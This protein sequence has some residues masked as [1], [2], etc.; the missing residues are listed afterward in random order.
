MTDQP[1]VSI[2]MPVFNSAR[3]LAEAVESV[4]AQTYTNWEL[5]ICDDGSV[6]GSREIAFRYSERDPRRIRALAHP[7]GGN[8]GVSATRNLGLRHASGDLIAML[9]ADDVWL[10]RKLEEQV[11]LIERWS[12][13]VLVGTSRYWHGWTGSEVDKKRDWT[14]ATGFSSPSLLGPPDFL[15]AM[16]MREAAV[17]CP[18]SVIVTHE[19]MRDVGGYEDEF[20]RLYEDQ[21]LYV[22]LC[23]NAKVLVVNTVWDLY[24]QHSASICSTD[25]HLE[26]KARLRYLLWTQNY[27]HEHGVTDSALWAALRH[28][29][30]RARFPRA[31]RMN[32]QFEQFFERAAHKARY[33]LRRG[34]ERA[35]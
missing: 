1:L 33:L 19:L 7:G 4:Q 10:P 24:R 17:P 34:T 9:D 5:V 13:G 23:V 11:A 20:P 14:P 12:A 3:F 2:L 29:I 35:G 28:E 18:T 6:D 21:V 25:S 32:E 31:K 30:R 15:T 8:L 16:L 26:R 22:K 27:L